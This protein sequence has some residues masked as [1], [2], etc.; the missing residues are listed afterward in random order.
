MFSMTL[1]CRNA[2][3][4]VLVISL[5]LSGITSISAAD[6]A[7][8]VPLNEVDTITILPIVFQPIKQQRTAPRILRAYT[9]NST[10]ISIKRYCASWR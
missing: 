7:G 3:A 8:T 10:T 4:L 9:A 2:V 5:L 6:G 1:S